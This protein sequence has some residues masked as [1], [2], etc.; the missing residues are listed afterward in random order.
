MYFE[1]MYK[2]KHKLTNATVQ[3]VQPIEFKDSL[4]LEDFKADIT[5]Q[6]LYR[7]LKEKL[8]YNYIIRIQNNDT[9]LLNLTSFNYKF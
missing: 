9:L 3:I 8:D 4:F 1:N 2:S 6:S 5:I 7:L